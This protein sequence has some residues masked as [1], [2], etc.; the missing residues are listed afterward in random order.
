MENYDTKDS[1]MKKIIVGV[2]ILF[3]S[4]MA[5]DAVDKYMVSMDEFIGKQLGLE[6][7][8]SIQKIIELSVLIKEDMGNGMPLSSYLNS[9]SGFEMLSSTL[10]SSYLR[11]VCKAKDKVELLKSGYLFRYRLYQESTLEEFYIIEIDEGSC[12]NIK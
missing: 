11:T 9:T 1:S 3:T 6:T 12:T 4:L 10:D 5:H 8:S 2:F 7:L